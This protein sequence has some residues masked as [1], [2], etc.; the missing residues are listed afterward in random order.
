MFR[1]TTVL[2]LVC[3]VGLV[4]CAVPRSAGA[5][6]MNPYP[7]SMP[8]MYVPSLPPPPPAIVYPSPRGPQACET[9]CRP[10]RD[11]GSRCTNVCYGG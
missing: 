10:L 7:P 1:S 2:A 9:V 4:G 5:Q 11:G 3:T 8:Q 6:F